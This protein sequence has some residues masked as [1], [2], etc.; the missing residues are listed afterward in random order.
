[1]TKGVGVVAALLAGLTFA[2]ATDGPALLAART[3][4]VPVDGVAPAALTDTYDQGR[5]ERRHEAL[6]IMAPRGTRVVAVDDGRIAKLFT[7]VP[8]GLTIYHF[9]P[10]GNL[11]YYYAHLDRYADGLKEGM[12]VRRGDTLGYVGT[13]GN[14]RM[15]APH[16][17][18]AVFRLGP[19]K[20]WWK[21]QPVNPYPALSAIRATAATAAFTSG[22]SRPRPS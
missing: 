6:D 11:A 13:S 12:T 19:E 10:A 16:L 20:Q 8:G 15:D 22:R 17:H 5:G 2:A 1:M 14:A 18:F 21:G 7:S 4:R 9:D 3:L